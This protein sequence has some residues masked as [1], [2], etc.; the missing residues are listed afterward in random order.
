MADTVT[1]ITVFNGPT[2]IVV[3]LTNVSDGTGE[4]AVK[5]VDIAALLNY[6]K[7]Q[8]AGL[9]IEQ[10]RWA[11]QGFQNVKLG[12]DR[13]AAQIT[14]ML[15]AGNGYD[16]LRGQ[17]A[18][19]VDAVKGF[20]KITGLVDPSEGNADAKG[21]ILLTTVGAVSGATYDITLWLRKA[22]NAS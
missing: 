13:T 11:M 21:S 3:H 16:D 12:W 8:P 15:L 1:T 7:V 2:N 20:T 18:G 10:V 14:A 5:K 4:S 9:R 22:D 19:G 6:Y 17:R